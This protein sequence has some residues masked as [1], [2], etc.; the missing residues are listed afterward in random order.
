MSFSTL[1]SRQR[2]RFVILIVSDDSTL[3]RKTVTK[4]TVELLAKAGVQVTVGKK[5]W[6]F[7]FE[8]DCNK[9]R[10]LF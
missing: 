8:L 9:R 10:Q 1:Q 3:T 5:H 7:R 4:P 6:E 2:F